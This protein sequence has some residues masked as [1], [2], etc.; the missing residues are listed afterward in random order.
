LPVTGY[1]LSSVNVF[2]VVNAFP[3]LL[4][5]SMRRGSRAR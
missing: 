4:V 3:M 1:F 2:V 5:H